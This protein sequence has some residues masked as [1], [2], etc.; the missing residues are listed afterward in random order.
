MH[1]T[2]NSPV[3][4]EPL[5]TVVFSYAL[6]ALDELVIHELLEKVY[7]CAHLHSCTVYHRALP[8]CLLPARVCIWRNCCCK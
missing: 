4:P 3:A 6:D 1:E 5:S 8:L 7:K 2:L